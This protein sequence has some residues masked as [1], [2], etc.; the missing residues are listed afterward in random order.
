MQNLQ[1]PIG[2]F[3]APEEISE[4]QLAD[5]IKTIELFP[6]KIKAAT[7]NLSDSELNTP[8][9]PD[10]WTIRQVVHHCADS[11][12]NSIIRLKLALTEEKPTVKV[13][14][15]AEWA[16]LND[17][18]NFNIHSSIIIIEGVHAR[19][20]ALLKSMSA[21][22]FNKTFI[23]PASGKEISLYTNTALYAWHCEHHLAHINLA[24]N[25]SRQA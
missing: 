25:N 9:R 5:F 3:T 22:D 19:W 17:S 8:Y 24:L 6:E 11:H 14:K 7:A 23:H 12:M 18:K 15:E 2:K 1:Y 20:V 16:N 4:N 21:N 10:G 13:Y